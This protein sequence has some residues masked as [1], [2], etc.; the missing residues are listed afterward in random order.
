MEQPGADRCRRVVCRA[1]EQGLQDDVL[2]AAPASYELLVGQ[3][4]PRH[5]VGRGDLSGLQ[6]ENLAQAGE[7]TEQGQR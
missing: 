3:A 7:M 2:D 6:L 5:L 4:A 1:V